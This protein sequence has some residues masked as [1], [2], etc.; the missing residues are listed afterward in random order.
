MLHSIS[1]MID[2]KLEMSTNYENVISAT[3]AIDQFIHSSNDAEQPLKSEFE[4]NSEQS[5][6]FDD[7]SRYLSVIFDAV[8]Y[9]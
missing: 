7:L 8:I 4:T 2:K 9:S 3:I 6:S 1:D 5:S